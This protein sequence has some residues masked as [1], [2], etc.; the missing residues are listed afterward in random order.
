M[1]SDAIQ[2]AIESNATGPKKVTGDSGSVEQHP[3][4]DQ[5]A[6]EKHLASK[7]AARSKG[8]GIKLIKI[9]PDGTI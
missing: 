9:S 4:T 3:I 1:A 7:Q 2:N 8:L 6:A 5:I